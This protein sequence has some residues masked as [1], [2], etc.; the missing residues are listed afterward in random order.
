MADMNK[1]NDISNYKRSVGEKPLKLSGIYF[2]NRII[3][4]GERVYEYHV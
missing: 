1:Q 3:N 2:S 4:W